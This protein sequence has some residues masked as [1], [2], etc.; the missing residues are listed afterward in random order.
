MSRLKLG[1]IEML[2]QYHNYMVDTYKI[3]TGDLH[4]NA[5]DGYSAESYSIEY[6]Y[7]NGDFTLDTCKNGFQLIFSVLYRDDTSKY[8]KVADFTEE[9]MADM[10]KRCIK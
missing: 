7:N 1:R 4:A 6:E 10:I 8:G 9:E 3:P 5:D 2:V